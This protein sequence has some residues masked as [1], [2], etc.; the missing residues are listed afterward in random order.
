VVVALA[1]AAAGLVALAKALLDVVDGDG[2]PVVVEELVRLLGD[3][4]VPAAR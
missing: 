2:R 1:R 3:L 4:V